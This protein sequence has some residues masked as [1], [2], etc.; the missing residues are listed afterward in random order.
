MSTAEKIQTVEARGWKNML[1]LPAEVTSTFQRE[2]KLH[3]RLW[4]VTFIPRAVTNA[5][6]RMASAASDI[7]IH[8]MVVPFTNNLAPWTDSLGLPEYPWQVEYA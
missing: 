4:P 3:R 1:A 8:P 5:S 2:T 7:L 6:F